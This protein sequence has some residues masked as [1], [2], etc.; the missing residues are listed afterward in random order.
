MRLPGEADFKPMRGSHV[1]VPIGAEAIVRTGGGGGWGNP[2]EREPEAVRHDVVEELISP[3]TA[4]RDYGV[5]LNARRE[6]DLEATRR[7]RDTMAN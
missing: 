2:L 6:V 3:E 7:R 1:A 4:L 5:V